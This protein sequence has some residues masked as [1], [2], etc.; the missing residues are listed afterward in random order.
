MWLPVNPGDVKTVAQHTHKRLCHAQSLLQWSYMCIIDS[1]LMIGFSVHE[2]ESYANQYLQTLDLSFVCNSRSV[3]LHLHTGKLVHVPSSLQME[4]AF[5][6]SWNPSLHESKIL[7]D[8]WNSSAFAPSSLLP[9]SDILGSVQVTAWQRSLP[10]FHSQSPLELHCTS[11]PPEI[12]VKPFVHVTATFA[13]NWGS[14]GAF[15]LTNIDRGGRLINSGHLIRS[16][17]SALLPDHCPLAKH[18]LVFKLLFK[19]W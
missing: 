3:E 10:Q 7:E 9:F 4:E 5:P 16:Q 2:T 14:W 11:S 17:N 12:F 6:I 1:C 15:P 19:S 18:T 13:P 8:T